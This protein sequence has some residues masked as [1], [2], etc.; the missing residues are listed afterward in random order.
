M[1]SSD[2]LIWN[3][4]IK[5][6]HIILMNYFKRLFLSLLFHSLY[7]DRSNLPPTK[8]FLDFWD[9]LLSLLHKLFEFVSLLSWRTISVASCCCCIVRR[10]WGSRKDDRSIYCKWY[11]FIAQ[12]C[13]SI[14]KHTHTQSTRTQAHKGSQTSLS[15]A[16]SSLQSCLYCFLKVQVSSHIPSSMF[17]I[18]ALCV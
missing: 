14:V 6:S 13:W 2:F 5:Y 1:C 11:T 7:F 15:N 12:W 10:W 8:S 16:H 4:W 17:S 9:H 18:T 3:S